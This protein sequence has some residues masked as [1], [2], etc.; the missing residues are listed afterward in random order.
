MSNIPKI[1][2]ALVLSFGLTCIVAGG[3]ILSFV[4]DSRL[5]G[6]FGYDLLGSGILATFFGVIGWLGAGY[7][8]QNNETRDSD[9]RH[10]FLSLSLLRK[11]VVIIAFLI[12]VSAGLGFLIG[13][14][15]GAVQLPAVGLAFGAI[16]MIWLAWPP[17]IANIRNT[18]RRS[19]I[20][21]YLTVGA[22]IRATIVVIA[23]SVYESPEEKAKRIHLSAMRAGAFSSYR[24]YN[25]NG[26]KESR[27]SRNLD[28]QLNGYAEWWHDNGERWAVEFY[29]GGSPHGLFVHWHSN[30]K[31]AWEAN[32]IEGV[33][34]GTAQAWNVD[35]NATSAEGIEPR[36]LDHLRL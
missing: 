17:L 16:M 36:T 26:K 2:A 33:L 11:V 20:R 31:K 5:F 14:A 27:I 19:L 22:T 3:W 30:G 24:Y 8:Q 10:A 21:F 7:R 15:R 29:A 9:V 32:Y 12:A 28:D 18:D 34:Q 4:E 23:V 35:G 6:K 1:L 25:E 13:L